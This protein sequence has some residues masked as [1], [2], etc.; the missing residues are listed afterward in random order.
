MKTKTYGWIVA[1]VGVCIGMALMW[2]T[3]QFWLGFVLVFAAGGLGEYFYIKS[4][5]E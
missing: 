1:G 3:K 4:K 2:V 5:K